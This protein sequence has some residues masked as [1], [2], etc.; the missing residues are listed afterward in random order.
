MHLEII[1]GATGYIGSHLA[2]SL[3][4][5]DPGKNL[6]CL[7][8]RSAAQSAEERVHQA[9]RRA[10]WDQGY[11][12]APEEL[13]ESVRVLEGD[14]CSSRAGFERDIDEWTGRPD[15][16]AFWHCAA[17]VS[18][19]ETADQAV[20]NTNVQG[21]QQTLN[22]AERLGADEFNHVSTAYVAGNRT[23]VILEALGEPE[24]GYTNIYEE[25]KSFGER[26]VRGFARGAGSPIESF[27][28]ASSS[29]IRR[30]CGRR[31]T[32]ASIAS[33]NCAGACGT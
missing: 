25:T 28:P 20:W 7:A 6:V 24:Q 31:A 32:P 27:V 13:L 19:R 33:R 17:S 12:E 30:R 4:L 21:L 3:L 18:F 2:A 22:V 11:D 9:L 5:K 8:R 23:G 14:L 29:A 26:L 15:R 10:W 16:V 1:T